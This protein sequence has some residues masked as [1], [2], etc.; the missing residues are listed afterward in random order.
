MSTALPIDLEASAETGVSTES[1][2]EPFRAEIATALGAISRSLEVMQA[3]L[4]ITRSIVDLLYEKNLLPIL[5]VQHRALRLAC[6]A[7]VS[8]STLDLIQQILKERELKINY[9]VQ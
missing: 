3:N 6:E 2:D 4:F 9:I 7:S 8:S 5:D 1:D